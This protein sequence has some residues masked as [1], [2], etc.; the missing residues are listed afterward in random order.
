MARIG[1]EGLK[2]A[3]ITAEGD[4]TTAPTYG[5]PAVIGKAV[6]AKL[7]PELNSAE[8]Y[9]DNSLAES[10]TTFNKG[11]LDLTVADD[12]EE[13]VA[14]LLGHDV[15]GTTS[16][17]TRSATDVAPYVGVGRV[18]TKIVGGAYKYKAEFLAK[19]KFKLTI[20]EEKTKGESV[21]F[22]TAPLSGDVI[23][24]LN[25]EWSKTKTFDTKAEAN[26][27]LDDCF[28]VA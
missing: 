6:D 17:I 7:N 12:D 21:E 26:A 13:T 23:V 18:I 3:L 27:F 9:A 19:V 16:E 25:G 1:L 15:D 8:L 24:P 10:D 11:S 20:P 28:G 22:Q 2:Y 14:T 5:T 4:A